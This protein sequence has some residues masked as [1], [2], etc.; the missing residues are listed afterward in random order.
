[1]LLQSRKGVQGQLRGGSETAQRQFSL[2]MT[3]APKQAVD[4]LAEQLFALALTSREEG[5]LTVLVRRGLIELSQQCCW[6]SHPTTMGLVCT[7]LSSWS[8]PEAWRRASVAGLG[9]QRLGRTRGRQRWCSDRVQ[10]RE[11]HGWVV[12]GKTALVRRQ[13]C[14]RH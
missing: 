4:A 14:H 11:L 12:L 1:M 7:L 13:M 2:S 5:R 8:S 3:F 9:V 10:P 6:C